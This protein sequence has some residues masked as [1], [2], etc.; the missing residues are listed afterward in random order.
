MEI[1]K[2]LMFG[3]DQKWK[4]TACFCAGQ[5]NA[6]QLAMP[7]GFDASFRRL[8]SVSRDNAIN[9]G[10]LIGSTDFTPGQASL[11]GMSSDFLAATARLV[12]L[13][14]GSQVMSAINSVSSEPYST[15]PCG[16]IPPIACTAP[17]ALGWPQPPYPCLPTSRSPS[18]P[19]SP[20]PIRWM[21]LPMIRP[22]VS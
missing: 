4:W 14:T 11:A 1:P 22:P 12:G 17:S 8:A 18:S 2:H 9:T 20:L 15:L 6:N 21:D 13:H 19:A 3:G 10:R 16:A 5:C 7:S